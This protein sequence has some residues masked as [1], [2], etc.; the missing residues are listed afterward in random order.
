MRG[1]FISRFKNELEIPISTLEGFSEAYWK[2]NI[3]T[4]EDIHKFF[5]FNK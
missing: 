3:K 5:K 1:A 2:W 4:W